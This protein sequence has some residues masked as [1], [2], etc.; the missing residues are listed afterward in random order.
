MNVVQNVASFRNYVQHQIIKQ[1]VNCWPGL[2]EITSMLASMNP[3]Q[4]QLLPF[5]FQSS[6]AFQQLLQKIIPGRDQYYRQDD[7]KIVDALLM[8]KTYTGSLLTDNSNEEGLMNLAKAA[9]DAV[10]TQVKK[11]PKLFT[12]KLNDKNNESLTAAGHLEK[13]MIP[14]DMEIDQNGGHL[15]GCELKKSLLQGDVMVDLMEQVIR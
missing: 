6:K 3:K 10:V 7:L 1:D 15:E 5:S 9:N 13:I 8:A 4:E 14:L 12:K 11:N 2:L